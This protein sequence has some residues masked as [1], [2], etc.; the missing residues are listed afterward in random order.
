MRLTRWIAGAFALLAVALPAHAQDKVLGNWHGVLQTP[1][2]P[3]TLVVMIAEDES[4]ALR[5]ELASPDQGPGKMPLT[6]ITATDRQIAFTIQS[7][8]ISYEGEWVEAEQHWSGVFVQG[9]NIP[10]TFRRGLP[11]ARP[12]VEGLDGQWHG[13]VARN[14]VNLRLVLRVATTDRGTMVT[15]DSPDLG[16]AGLPVAGLSRRAQDVAFSVPA[17]GARFIG[18]LSDDGTRIK[19]LW[20]VPGQPDTEVTFVRTRT[21]AERTPP[22][23]PQTPKPPFP[24]RAETVTFDNPVA[25]GVTLAGTLTLPE[26]AGPFPA[27]VL[28]TGSGPQD[29][30][31]T[32]LGHRSFAVLADH[33]TRHGVA[34]LRYDDR[35]VGLST[36]DFAAA[37]SADFATD[38]T[39]AVRFLLTRPEIRR[40]GIGFIGHSEGGMVAQIAAAHDADIDFVVLLAAPGTNLMQLAQSQERLLG[41][42]QGVSEEELARMQPVMTAVF[43]AVATSTSA[44]D[45][46]A[47]VRAV[48]SP[49]ALAALK[50]PESR[51]ELLVQQMA[52]D[53]YRYLLQYKPAA[54]LSR[55]RV[56]LL[57]LNGTLD[58][59]VPADENLSAIKTALAHNTDVTIRKLD[60]LNHLF[61][62][63]HTGAIGEYED[64]EETI[65]PVVLSVVTGWIEARFKRNGA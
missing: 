62:T 47:R 46:R 56:P 35:G 60:G 41:L 49:G 14:G 30:D 21:T 20:T 6:T 2:G 48:L 59:Q 1:I 31:Q 18:T 50:A 44:E 16:A 61:Q 19:G 32:L 36:G 13:S 65:A 22:V 34:V 17:S 10:L 26:G 40:E 28:L 42:S 53:W 24:Y 25:A 57:A 3:M 9:A 12:V 5:G 54:S 43:T 33:L 55:I 58:R 23:R 52:N 11:P 29:R 27:A 64:I 15:F 8:R 39:A 63:A 51:R 4:G 38:A 37:T 45:A 7:A